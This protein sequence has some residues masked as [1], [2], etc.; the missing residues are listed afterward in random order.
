LGGEES[1]Y[2][3]RLHHFIFFL[4]VVEVSVTVIHRRRSVAG[5]FQLFLLLMFFISSDSLGCDMSLRLLKGRG[6]WLTASLPF[7]PPTGQG[8]SHLWLVSD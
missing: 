4:L 5:N 7:L 1:G 6:E 8:V 2:V 3:R